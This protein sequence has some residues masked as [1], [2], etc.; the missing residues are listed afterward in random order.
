M[1]EVKL[2]SG[3]VLRVNPAPFEEAKA[4][5]RA[6]LAEGRDVPFSAQTD[7]ASVLKDLYCIGFSSPKV[8][9]CLDKCLGRC[10][11]NSGKGNLKIDKDTFEQVECR[12]DYVPV[13]LEVFK[14]N[15][16]PFV[17]DLF[18]AYAEFSKVIGNSPQ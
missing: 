11:Y 12:V 4:L 15:I 13:C 16:G 3:A 17:K 10:T 8:E 6:F 7:I 1:R 5:Y 2:P 18:A 14:E 9:E